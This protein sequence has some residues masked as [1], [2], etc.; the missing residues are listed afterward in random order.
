MAG[1][2]K[3]GDRQELHEAIRRHSLEAAKR[4]KQDGLDNDLLERIAKDPAFGLDA[5][6]LRDVMD[7]SKFVGRSPEITEEFL[8]AEVEPVLAR[9]AGWKELDSEDLRV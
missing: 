1:V 8:A 5:K 3:G 7:P 9:H 2:K 6:A 4:V